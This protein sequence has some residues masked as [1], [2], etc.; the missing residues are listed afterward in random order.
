MGEENMTEKNKKVT[1]TD[2]K[3]EVIRLESQS[4]I[5]TSVGI[6]GG[7]DDWSNEQGNNGLIDNEPRV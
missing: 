2:C 5:V 6:M 7:K 4:V 1:F 3:T